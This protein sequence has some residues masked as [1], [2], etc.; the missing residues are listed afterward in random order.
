[1]HRLFCMYVCMYIQGIVEVGKEPGDTL[2]TMTF[3]K[4]APTPRVCMYVCMYVDMY[5]DI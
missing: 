1:M 3:D 4:P 2:R 5:V